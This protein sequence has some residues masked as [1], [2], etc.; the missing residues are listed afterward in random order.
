MKQFKNFALIVLL[1]LLKKKK[2]EGD[3]IGS[4][5]WGRERGEDDRRCIDWEDCLIE[6]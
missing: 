1:L 5:C 3:L 4:H 6:L 2:R